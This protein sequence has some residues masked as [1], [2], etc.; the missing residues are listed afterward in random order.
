MENFGTWNMQAARANTCA[1]GM[2]RRAM[3]DEKGKRR[4]MTR[5]ARASAQ[6]EFSRARYAAWNLRN[7][8]WLYTE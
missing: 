1:M 8:P 2:Y 5:Q 6:W 4:I 3:Y 7:A